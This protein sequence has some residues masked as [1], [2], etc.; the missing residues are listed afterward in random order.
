M[1]ERDNFMWITRGLVFIENTYARGLSVTSSSTVTPFYQMPLK[2]LIHRKPVDL[3]TVKPWR[4]HVF[5][6]DER[7]DSFTLP[8]T[9]KIALL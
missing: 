1:C 6:K 5:K 9:E 3:N 8:G 7:E 2:S 4:S